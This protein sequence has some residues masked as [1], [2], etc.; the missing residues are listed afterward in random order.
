M[1]KIIFSSLMLL[2][3]SAFAHNLPVNS[4]WSSDYSPGKGMYKLNVISNEEV[5]LVE[6]KNTCGFDQLGNLSFCTRMAFFPIEGFL[7]VLKIRAPRTTLVY[8]LVNSEFRVLH[9]TVDQANGF[10]RLQKVDNHGSVIDS[11]RLFKD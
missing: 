8:S 4:S 11:I 6:D 7:E 1:K 10:I 3:T 9:S 5:Q 2:S